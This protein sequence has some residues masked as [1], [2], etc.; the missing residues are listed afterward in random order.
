MKYIQSLSLSSQMLLFM[1]TSHRDLKPPPPLSQEQPSAKAATRGRRQSP[2]TT[3]PPAPMQ[4]QVG[5]QGPRN[6]SLL[7]NVN[8]AS[9]S[10]P[11]T[12]RYNKRPSIQKF[13]TK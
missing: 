6:A 5:Y 7:G 4:Q 2:Q 9:S 1:K 11:A 10:V 3:Q 8:P 13:W 12:R